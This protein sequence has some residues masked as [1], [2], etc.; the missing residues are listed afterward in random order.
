VS[1]RGRVPDRFAGVFRAGLIGLGTLQT[2]NGLYA[3]IA[4]RSFYDDFPFGQGWVAALPQYSEHLVRD[5]GGL[6]LATAVVLLAAAIYLERRLV[7]IA[8]ISFLAF[9]LPHSVF[10]A[11]NLEPYSTADL[12]GNVIGLGAMVIVPALL[13]FLLYA[14][15]ERA[16]GLSGADAARRDP[17]R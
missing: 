12:L 1:E 10:H 5:V 8:L 13:L 15:P 14:T 7:A 9:S 3:L 17:A 4:P 16:P 11:F 6:F 2:V